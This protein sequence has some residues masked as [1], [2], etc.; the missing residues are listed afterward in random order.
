M[1]PAWTA[2]VF[3]CHLLF[4][5]SCVK[6]T[7]F[8]HLISLESYSLDSHW[9]WELQ[10]CRRRIAGSKA[11]EAFFL[12]IEAYPFFI[13]QFYTAKS[14]GQYRDFPHTPS[15]HTCTASPTITI[16]H[17]SGT[18]VTSDKPTPTQHYHPKFIV[19]NRVHSWCFAFYGFGQMCYDMNVSIVI[20]SYRVFRCPKNPLLS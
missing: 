20:V 8:K 3:R 11:S 19:H 4:V 6:F 17:Q 5:P 12:V 16:L 9:L 7:F 15:L 14:K 2:Y 10:L 18:L 13:E 1:P